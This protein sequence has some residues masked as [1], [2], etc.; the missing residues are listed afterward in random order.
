MDEFIK[1]PFE[2]P[3]ISK[4]IAPIILHSL[5]V[6]TFIFFLFHLDHEYS[7]VETGKLYRLNKTT[8]YYY[9]YY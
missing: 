1:L 8:V 5:F 7:A 4:S 9:Y 3:L 2:F 6:V